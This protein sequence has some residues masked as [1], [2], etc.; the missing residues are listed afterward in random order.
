MNKYILVVIAAFL[1]TACG[2]DEK[3]TIDLEYPE[4]IVTESSFP[5]QCSE[6]NRGGKLLFSALFRDNVELGGYSLDIHHNFDQHTH[7]TEVNDCESDPVKS[8]VDPML[9]IQTYTIPAG[10]SEYQ[11]EA[12]IDIPSEI[13]PGDYHFMIRLTDNEGWQTLQGISIKIK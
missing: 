11:A 5:I 10:L 9:F 12:E 2:E 8:A 7:S 3:P 6:V 1:L 13:D 4:I